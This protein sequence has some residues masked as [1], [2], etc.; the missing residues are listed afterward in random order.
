MEIAERP[1]HASCVDHYTINSHPS[2][3]CHC[4]LV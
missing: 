1:W 3:V 4:Q 2:L